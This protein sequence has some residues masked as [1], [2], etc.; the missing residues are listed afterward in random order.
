[1]KKMRMEEVKRSQTV[2]CN[3]TTLTVGTRHLSGGE[4]EL[5]IENSHGVR[6]IW[7]EYFHSAKSAMRGGFRAIENEG[8]ETFSSMEGFEYKL[9]G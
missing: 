1:M 3:G 2:V 9:N 7:T 8:V 4:W 6:S 5:F